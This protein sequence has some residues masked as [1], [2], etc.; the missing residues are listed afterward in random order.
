MLFGLTVI[1]VQTGLG[2]GM[3]AV[4][5]VLQY[6]GCPL[7]APS[8]QTSSVKFVFIHGTNPLAV[9]IPCFPSVLLPPGLVLLSTTPSPQRAI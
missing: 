7:F 9:L 6:H 4:H 2:T 3:V 8:S 1:D 5:V